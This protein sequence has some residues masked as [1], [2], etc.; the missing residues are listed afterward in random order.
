[1]GYAGGPEHPTFHFIA[2]LK[3]YL[4]RVGRGMRRFDAY[5]LS[6]DYWGQMA[7]L[8]RAVTHGGRTL[9]S[10]NGNLNE[11][12]A[13]IDRFR[14]EAAALSQARQRQE[15][16]LGRPARPGDLSDPLRERYRELASRVATEARR[17]SDEARAR[18]VFGVQASMGAD[19]LIGMEDFTIAA[20]TSL[21]I[22]PGYSRL[23][24]SWYR[25][26]S[27]RAVEFAVLARDGAYGTSPSLVFA[28]VHGI[29]HDTARQAGR[30]AGEAGVDGVACGLAGALGDP[31]STDF[32]VQDGRVQEL[33]GLVPR[34]YLRVLDVAAGLHLGFAHAAGRR[35]R[36]HALG[37]G[38][39]ILVPLLALLG[40]RGTFTAAD[41]TAPI[42]DADSSQTI[43]LYIDDP[44]PLKLKAHRIAEHWLEEGLAWSCRCPY[45]RRFDA[46]HPPR[47]GKARTWWRAEGKR[48][49][50][51]T[52]MR[53][54]SPLADLLPLLGSA[55][56][57]VVRRP[58]AAARIGHNHWVLRRLERAAQAH[59]RSPKALRA[60]AADVVAAYEASSGDPRWKAATRAAWRV[61]DAAAE[62]LTGLAPGGELVRPR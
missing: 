2:N 4:F 50:E 20:L 16:R 8:A 41:S 44:A 29:D 12:V 14:P 51:P 33:E 6:A 15:R 57:P 38:T 11:I 18:R 52:D 48:R 60:W 7:P 55:A 31:G 5:L 27:E 37:V 39:P 10:D 24:L 25:R 13:L 30:V 62:E 40:D 58:A 61:A 53:A 32:R 46:E 43:A 34:P 49:L 21:G 45:C 19:Y 59:A 17:A 22:E 23:P 28:G 26:R 9:V 35:P 42:L 3:P 56:D 54:P 36:F 1:M 47:P